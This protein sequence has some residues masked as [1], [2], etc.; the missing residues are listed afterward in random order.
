MCGEVS[1]E[2][3]SVTADQGV[4]PLHRPTGALSETF[5]REQ[6]GRLV[7]LQD[8]AFGSGRYHSTDVFPAAG[9]AETAARGEFVVQRGVGEVRVEQWLGDGRW[10]PDTVH[11]E[12][13]VAGQAEPF[14]IQ[15][16]SGLLDLEAHRDDPV[17]AQVEG[18]DD[19][20]L[21]QANCLDGGEQA[22]QRP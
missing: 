9:Q 5:D 21:L 8:L 11:G 22:V 15:Q 13:L 19:A 1:G 20:A 2:S 10:Q 12:R 16:R 17:G 18:A 6:R 14:Q 7:D 4:T 3:E